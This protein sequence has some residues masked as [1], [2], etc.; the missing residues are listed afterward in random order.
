MSEA[1]GG[2]HRGQSLSLTVAGYVIVKQIVNMIVGGFGGLNL[3]ILFWGAIAGICFYKGVKKS[4]LFF[5]VLMMVVACAYFPQ[6]IMHFN[7]LYI[8]EGVL[9]MLGA[10]LLAFHPDIRAHCKCS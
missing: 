6:N 5:A 4:N 3:F 1:S 9:D 2:F 7:L 8:I 10:V